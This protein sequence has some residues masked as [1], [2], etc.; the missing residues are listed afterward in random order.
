MVAVVAVAGV[1][2]GVWVAASRPDSP[3][4]RPAVRLPPSPVVAQIPVTGEPRQLALDGDELWVVTDRGLHRIDTSTNQVTASVPVG[5]LTVEPGGLGLSADAVW[6]PGERSELLWRIDQ[7]TTR[8]SGPIRLGQVLYGPVGVAVQGDT[9][10]V[11]CCAL[12]YGPR[13]AGMLLRVDGRRNQVTARLP[14]PEGPMAVVADRDAVWVG[15]A[16]GSLLRVDPASGRVTTRVPPPDPDGRI[17]ALSFGSGVLW[18]ADTGA[19]AIR[20]LDTRTGRYDL[21]VT[22]PAPRNLAAGPDGAWVVTDLNRLLS[23]VDGR[24]GRRGAPIPLEHLGGVRGVGVGPGAV[25]V[26]TGNQVL[27]LDPARVAQPPS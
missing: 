22:A 20:R 12:K 27:R 18:V 21:A 15:T 26:T 13:P 4:A 9:I 6:V 19:G 8:I 10:W 1:S 3:A 24:S 25:W 17:Q 14:V 5:T 16:R 23:R 7:A 2:V 11:A